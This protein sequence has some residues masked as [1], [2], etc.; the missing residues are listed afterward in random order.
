MKRA[1]FCVS[2]HKSKRKLR[3]WVCNDTLYF[4]SNRQTCSYESDCWG[5]SKR[6][7]TILQTP[8]LSNWL[9]SKNFIYV[10]YVP[11]KRRQIVYHRPNHETVFVWRHLLVYVFICSV[12]PHR[13]WKYLRI[14]FMYSINSSRPVSAMIHIRTK[15]NNSFSCLLHLLYVVRQ[16]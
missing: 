7:H 1:L 6:S 3:N 15:W 5:F 16:N 13:K 4:S 2:Y 11:H 14:K 12:L 8:H 9:N 10:P